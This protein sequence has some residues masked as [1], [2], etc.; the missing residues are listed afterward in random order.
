[1]IKAWFLPKFKGKK[2]H[3]IERK[4]KKI[5]KNVTNLKLIRKLHKLKN[6][7]SGNYK[8]RKF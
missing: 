4:M 1:M 6:I 7:I 5:K 3:F 8:K 2:L